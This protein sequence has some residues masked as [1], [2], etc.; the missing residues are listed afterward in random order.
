MTAGA[1]AFTTGHPN[2]FCERAERTRI[3]V[4]GVRLLSARHCPLHQE[5]PNPSGNKAQ[6]RFR[7]VFG[8]MRNRG[9]CVSAAGVLTV[10]NAVCR[11]HS[12]PRLPRFGDVLPLGINGPGL[13]PSSDN[14]N[15]GACFV[16]GQAHIKK[17]L[18]PKVKC[19]CTRCESN[20]IA[21]G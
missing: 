6:P 14:R 9:C 10:W 7:A 11:L 18:H 8:H 19:L 4:L 21:Y 5:Y 15:A 12:F 17:T 3:L 13:Q 2:T 20:A 16:L 1:D